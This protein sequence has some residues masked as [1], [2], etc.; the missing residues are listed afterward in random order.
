MG[1]ATERQICLHRGSVSRKDP[2]SVT[3]QDSNK[4]IRLES[5]ALETIRYLLFWLVLWVRGRY[6][7]LDKNLPVNN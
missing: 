5:E 2:L 4:F 7:R 1:K 6:G 3:L